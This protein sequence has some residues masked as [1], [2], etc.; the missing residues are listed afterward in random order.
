MLD[1]RYPF[2]NKA[3]STL[4]KKRNLHFSAEQLRLLNNALACFRTPSSVPFPA[5]TI[6][7]AICSKKHTAGFE[8]AMNGLDRSY[9]EL[10]PIC[11]EF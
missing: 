11:F 1:T 5:V 6:P 8:P 2:P 4:L 7:L 9:G 10:N 3:K